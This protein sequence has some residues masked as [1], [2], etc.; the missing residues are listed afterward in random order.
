[1]VTTKSSL[2]EE[3]KREKS[4]HNEE[5]EEEEKEEEGEEEEEEEESDKKKKSKL[6]WWTLGR[7]R[8]KRGTGW[9][10]E[11][12]REEERDKGE[13]GRPSHPPLDRQR[14]KA[15]VLLDVPFENVRTWTQD[16]LE[17]RPVQ[18]DALQRAAGDH[19]GGAGSV[20]QQGDLAW[21]THTRGTS[22]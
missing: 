1:M 9:R 6:H 15:V 13:K 2:C 8:R 3:P 18:L 7:K 12:G 14:N 20:H 10:N 5:E 4:Q 22:F 17:A 19:G 21:K 11:R 16:A